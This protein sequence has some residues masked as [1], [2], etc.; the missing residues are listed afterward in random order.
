[1]IRCLDASDF[2]FKAAVILLNELEE[3]MLR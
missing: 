3:F 1:M 2:G